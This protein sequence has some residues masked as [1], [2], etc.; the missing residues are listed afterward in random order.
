MKARRAKLDDLPSILFL[1]ADDVLG[2]SRE[3]LGKTPHRNYICAFKA[4]NADPNQFLAVFEEQNM[5]IGCLQLTFIPTLTRL[6][7]LRCQIEG[8]RVANELRGQGYGRKMILWAIEKSRNDGCK[9]I[10]LTSD[11][12][13]SDALNFYKSMGFVASHEG[14]KIQI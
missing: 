7:A 6:G 11:K 9:L 3:E 1:L 2:K 5:I 14:F 8:V 13:R 12:T 4:I 10:Q